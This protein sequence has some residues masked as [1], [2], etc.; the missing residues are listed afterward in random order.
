M[1]EREGEICAGSRGIT[2][3]NEERLDDAVEDGVVIVTLQPEPDE[4]TGD[5]VY[6]LTRL[7][8]VETDIDR[9][10]DPP[11]EITSVEVLW[12]PFDD[13]VP[14]AVPA[15]AL[16]SSRVDV[17]KKASKKIAVNTT[18]KKMINLQ[19]AE[20]ASVKTKIKSSHDVL[21]DP[22]L[23]KREDCLS[24]KDCIYTFDGEISF[25]F[26]RL[27]KSLC[28]SQCSS[29]VEYIHLFG[30]GDAREKKLDSPTE[31]AED[32]KN[33]SGESKS[34]KKKD[35]SSK[36]AKE[37][38]DHPNGTDPTNESD[39]AAV[40]EKAEVDTPVV[41]GKE[42]VN[43]VARM[44]KNNNT[45]NGVID[46]TSISDPLGYNMSTFLQNIY[47][48]DQSCF[49]FLRIKASGN[50]IRGSKTMSLSVSQNSCYHTWWFSSFISFHYIA[51]ASLAAARNAKL[52]AAKKKE[53][54]QYN[55]Q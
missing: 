30:A 53:K 44:K 20:L 49:A 50:M 55:Q 36:E 52:A 21:N 14:R 45:V 40:T 8:E 37:Q 19:K 18:G 35:K 24:K 22:H 32:K 23:L 46:Q 11:P 17:D 31:E 42:K 2:G 6:S 1:N 39:E 26:S 38:Q 27:V 28:W 15:E 9:P 7:G 41:D 5:S 47:L 10:L 51:A 43:K 12:N 48:D 3:S 4:V 54:N 16:P 29:F 33:A 34:T 25:S 13:I